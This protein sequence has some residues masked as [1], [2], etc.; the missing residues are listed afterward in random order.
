ML[1]GYHLTMIER[2]DKLQI[3]LCIR[4]QLCNALVSK[5]GQ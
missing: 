1:K 3:W 4:D 5:F 2:V